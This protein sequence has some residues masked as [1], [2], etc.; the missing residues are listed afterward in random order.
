MSFVSSKRLTQV[1][2]IFLTIVSMVVTFKVEATPILNNTANQN[3]AITINLP[4]FTYRQ[5]IQPN[6]ITGIKN[7]AK[8]GDFVMLRGKF[9]R[10]V[11]TNILEF[12]DDGKQAV[13]VNFENDKQIHLIHS[14]REYELWGKVVRNNK[15]T[16]VNAISVSSINK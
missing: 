14:L 10:K 13:F 2:L 4:E 9:I 1:S 3:K 6:S 11:D 7:N 8:V 12:T 5:Q 16:F 15:L